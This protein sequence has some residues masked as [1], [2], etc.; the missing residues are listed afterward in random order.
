MKATPE[1]TRPVIS[2][3]FSFEDSLAAFE[4]MESHN[5]VGKTVIKVSQ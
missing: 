3:V 2:K 4:H 1:A 5:A